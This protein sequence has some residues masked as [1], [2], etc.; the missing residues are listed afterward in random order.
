MYNSRLMTT[1]LCVALAATLSSC[2]LPK[3]PLLTYLD[4]NAA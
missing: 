2:A 1:G 4:G 3:Q